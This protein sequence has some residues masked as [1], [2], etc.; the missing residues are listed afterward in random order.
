MYST[1]GL[2][3]LDFTGVF[4]LTIWER[5]VHAGIYDADE[6]KKDDERWRWRLAGQRKKGSSGEEEDLVRRRLA[7]QR[8]KKGSSREEKK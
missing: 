1:R 4:G 5:H 8:K 2:G 6:Q 7:G 3:E